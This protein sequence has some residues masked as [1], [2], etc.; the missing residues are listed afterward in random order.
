MTAGY[1]AHADRFVIDRLPPPEAQPEW[2]LGSLRYPERLNAVSVLLDRHIAQGYGERRALV[3]PGAADWSYATLFATV[4][5]IANVLVHE[6]GVVPGTRVLLR[7]PNSPMLV[8]CW[9][10][11]LK[12]GGIAVTTMPLYR[13]TELRT[14]V[15]RA[16]V[17]L[18]LCDARLLDELRDAVAGDDRVAIVAFGSDA[19]GSLD[20]RLA[21]ASD[22]FQAVE[23]AAEDPAIVAFTSGT[24]GAPKAAVHAHRALVATCDTFGAAILRP[25]PDDLFCGSPPLAFTYG[26]GGQLLFP[27]HAGASTLLLERAGAQE[28]LEAIARYRVT[29][30]FTAPI[31]YRAM[32]AL[33]G[34]YDLTSLHTC[35]SAGEPLPKVVW[36]AWHERTGLAIVDGIG[37]TEMLHIF[38]ASPPEEARAGST[39]RAV[40]GYTAQI[41]DDDGVPLPPGSVGRLAVKGPTGCCYL[42]DDRQA[43]YVQRGWNYPGDAYRMD[44]DG[45]FWYVARTDDI[46]VTAGFNVSGPEVE[47]ALLGHAAVRECAVVG[48]P[49]PAHDTNIVKAFVVLMDGHAASEALATTLREH[50]LA[51]I[52]PFKAPREIEFV[53]ELP[54]TAT[55]KVQRYKLRQAATA[56]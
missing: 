45:Y 22:E 54:R 33:A 39:G 20:A 41:H 12:A 15:D 2:V 26:L 16:R 30:L 48:K 5:R 13:A 29:T 18:A 19:E 32:S 50:C 44:E 28:L 37:S 8:A 47:Q 52:A 4:N 6:L 55:G 34:G 40:P 17:T 38:I 21:H 31:A 36:E 35:V 51:T 56:E 53:T 7:A 25:K 43:N 23:T 46:I 11:V 42:G 49:D 10:A 3:S 1:S 14:V 9:F 27:M 24:T